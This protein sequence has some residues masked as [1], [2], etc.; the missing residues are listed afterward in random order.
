MRL[1][2]MLGWMLWTLPAGL[3]LLLPWMLVLPPTLVLREE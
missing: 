1:L 2:W 3:K